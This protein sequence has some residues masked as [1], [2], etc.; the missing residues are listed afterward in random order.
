MRKRAVARTQARP[1]PVI[2]LPAIGLFLTLSAI[3]LL[4]WWA[5]WSVR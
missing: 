3:M 2:N 1:R 4:G 5:F